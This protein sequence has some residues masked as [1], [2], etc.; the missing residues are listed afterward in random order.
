MGGSGAEQ[1][2]GSP[3]SLI[4]I[5]NPRSSREGMRLFTKE[6]DVEPDCADGLDPMQYRWFDDR[7]CLR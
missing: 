4:L 6:N 2:V 7:R 5:A 1:T 3:A